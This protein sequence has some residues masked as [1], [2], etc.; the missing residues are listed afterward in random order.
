MRQGEAFDDALSPDLAPAA[1]A[2]PGGTVGTAYSQQFTATNGAGSAVH[3]RHRAHRRA[4]GRRDGWPAPRP[5]YK[6]E[7]RPLLRHADDGG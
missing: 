7:Q 4:P 1:G 5:D 6:H 3:L 2:L